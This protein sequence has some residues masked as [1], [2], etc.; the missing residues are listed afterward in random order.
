MHSSGAVQQFCWQ[1]VKSSF[2]NLIKY[3]LHLLKTK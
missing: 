2:P 1:H 3:H